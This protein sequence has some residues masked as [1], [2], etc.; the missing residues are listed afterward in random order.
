MDLYFY[1]GRKDLAAT[2]LADLA[3]LVAALADEF[4]PTNALTIERIQS[5]IDS[6]VQSDGGE[7]L[8]LY[9]YDDA[10]TVSS[11]A[12]DATVTLS[13]GLGTPDPS[14]SDLYAV[15]TSFTVASPR[16]GTLALNT[17]QLT[18]ALGSAAYRRRGWYGQAAPG[19]GSVEGLFFLHV[20]KTLASGA[21]ETVGLLPV[22]VQAGVLNST[23]SL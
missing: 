17:S 14:N 21:T 5:K 11:W 22:T 8:N 3:L 4:N 18:V 23:A 6:L 1:K 20:R 9:F 15:T 12:T 2:T 7:P 10:S 16:V 13:V 19:A